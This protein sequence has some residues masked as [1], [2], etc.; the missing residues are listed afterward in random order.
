[1]YIK[2]PRFAFKI[3][4]ILRGDFTSWANLPNKKIKLVLVVLNV[5]IEVHHISNIK[6]RSIVS[7]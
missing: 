3:L 5:V 7:R 4:A 6:I 1:M 2:K